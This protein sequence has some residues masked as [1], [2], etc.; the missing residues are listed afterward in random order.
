[1]ETKDVLVELLLVEGLEGKS[2]LPGASGGC[3]IFTVVELLRGGGGGGGLF[4]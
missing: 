3:N 1:M 4:A 2:P